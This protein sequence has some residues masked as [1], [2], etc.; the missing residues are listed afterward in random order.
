MARVR[1]LRLNAQSA[2]R[3]LLLLARLYDLAGNRLRRRWLAWRHPRTAPAWRLW[4]AAMAFLILL[5]MPLGNLLPCL[6]LVLLAL[7]WIYRDGLALALSLVMGTAAV[8]FFAF[9]AHLLVDLV[10]QMLPA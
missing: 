8:A 3:C 6:S 10:G 1:D 5:P 2:R 9:S 4:I 7:G